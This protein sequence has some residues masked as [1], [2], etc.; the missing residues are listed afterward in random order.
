MQYNSYLNVQLAMTEHHSLGWPVLLLFW[1]LSSAFASDAR[2]WSPAGLL[3]CSEG[4]CARTADLARHCPSLPPSRHPTP[5]H[6]LAAIQL[7][8]C[9]PLRSMAHQ[10]ALRPV[11]SALGPLA[12]LPASS[13]G[14]HGVTRA[15]VLFDVAAGVFGAGLLLHGWAVMDDYRGSRYRPG[16]RTRAV[17]GICECAQRRCGV[18]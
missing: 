7:L 13:D 17:R 12:L 4:G 16:W 6:P 14:G 1:T 8:V 10:P 9:V 18:G 11:L 15:D 5:T 3:A 2:G